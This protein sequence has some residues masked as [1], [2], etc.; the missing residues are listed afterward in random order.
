MTSLALACS[1]DDD[2]RTCGRL[3]T[4]QLETDLGRV[5]NLSGSGMGVLSRQSLA[6]RVGETLEIT[7]TA[8]DEETTVRA[9]IIWARRIGFR[10][11][12]TGLSFDDLAEDDRAW[13][14]DLA[15]TAIFLPGLGNQYAA[16]AIEKLAS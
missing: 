6:D 10:K 9:T 13:L 2:R 16:T 14:T 7:L 4:E 8:L 1:R 12:L 15:R 3:R 11:H 5:V